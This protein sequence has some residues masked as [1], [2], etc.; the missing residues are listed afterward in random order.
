MMPLDYKE[1]EMK[2]IVKLALLAG[3]AYGGY[4]LYQKYVKQPEKAQNFDDL[5]EEGFSYDNDAA[6]EESFADKIRAAAE[7]QLDRIK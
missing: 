4:K 1:E 2:G 3:A 6:N 7:R 5:G